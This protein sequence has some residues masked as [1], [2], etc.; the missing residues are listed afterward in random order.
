MTVE[1]MRGAWRRAQ[2]ALA[3]AI[4]DVVEVQLPDYFEHPECCDSPDVIVLTDGYI[5]SYR[6]ELDIDE[7]TAHAESSGWGDMSE[8]GSR[9]WLECTNC[10][11]VWEAPESLEW[12]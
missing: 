6:V 4:S 3:D 11:A 2:K 10:N 7:R 1:E 9:T 12:N 8:D 5:G